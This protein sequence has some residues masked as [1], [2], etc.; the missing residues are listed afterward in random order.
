MDKV[1]GYNT[2]QTNTGQLNEIPVGLEFWGDAEGNTAI[3]LNEGPDPKLCK[4][5]TKKIDPYNEKPND[6][7]ITRLPC[8]YDH[9]TTK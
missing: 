8:S 7:E 6:T 9:T 1:P 2:P 3:N 4:K 5:S